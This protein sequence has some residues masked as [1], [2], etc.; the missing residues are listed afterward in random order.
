MHTI[1]EGI[2]RLPKSAMLKNSK[3]SRC[4]QL[5]QWRPLPHSSVVGDQIDHRW[6]QHKES[7]VEPCSVSF[8]L[9]LETRNPRLLYI[10]RAV[11]PRRL[12]ACQRC[13][14]PFRMMKI[15]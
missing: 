3:L 10:Q 8:G 5:L 14:P 2:H 1:A 6:F 4:R 11:S 15:N 9:L 7:T 13:C 12:Y